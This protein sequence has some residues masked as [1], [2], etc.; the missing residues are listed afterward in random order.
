MKV[1]EMAQMV[2][3]LRPDAKQWVVETAKKSERSQNWLI[4]KIIDKAM[5][6]GNAAFKREN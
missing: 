2:I 5:E 3:R 4:G 1:R 6:E